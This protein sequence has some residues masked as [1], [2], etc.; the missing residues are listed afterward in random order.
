MTNARPDLTIATKVELTP[1]RVAQLPAPGMNV[2]VQIR[3]SPDGQ[4]ISF[5]Y[6][7]DGSLTR[8]LWAWDARTGERELLVRPPDGGDTDANVSR[9][10]AMRRERQRQRGFG[11]TSYAWSTEGDTLLVPVRGA[12]YVQH[13]ASGPLRMVA[14]GEP[15]C[16]DPQLNH[17]G[18]AVAF[19]RQGELYS[20]DLTD[21]TD[22]TDLTRDGAK[23]VRLTFDATPADA[24]EQLVTNGQAEFVA[25]E[26]MGRSHGFW[27]SR[28]GQ[29][30][31]VEQV[32][33]S[34]V[35]A[36]TIV[37]QGE[38][39]VESETHR[40][41]FAGGRDAAVRLGVV[42]AGGGN[43]TWLPLEGVTGADGYL[44]RV[45]WAPDG[46][47]L[48]QVLDR[49]QQTLELRRIDPRSRASVT[50]IAETSADW[51]N[52]HDDLHFVSTGDGSDGFQVLWSSE[53]T[54]TRQ[55]YLCE[56][57]GKLTRQI[58]DGPWP[59]DRVVAVDDRSRTVFFAGAES[60]LEM[61]LYRAGLDDGAPVR[62]T[63]EPGIHSAVVSPDH[64]RFVDSLSAMT[65]APAVSLRSTSA[66]DLGSEARSLFEVQ[67]PEVQALDLHP[68]E[69]VILRARDGETL[70]G[71][72]YRP[73]A[74]EPGR[75]YPVLVS[76]YG[77]PH[78]QT[79]NN[80]WAM[81]A[82]LR[83]QYL[84]RQ[85]F[86]VMKLDN[87][88]SSRRGHAFEAGLYR[89][90]GG[91]EVSDQVDGV[92]F[93]ASLPEADTARTGVYGWSYGGYLTLMCLLKAPDIF[94]AG[95]AGAPV[96]NWDG[97]DTFYTERY[98]QTPQSNPD[99]YRESAATTHAARLEGRLLLLHGMLDENVHFRHTA[100]L[101][102]ALNE[103]NR[104][105]DL[106]VF[107]G[108]R[109]GPRSEAQ[110]AALERRLAGFF[111]QHLGD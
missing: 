3:F 18:S 30:I 40:Y 101:I 22:P 32:D 79:V 58:T 43:V 4:R 63:A 107:P 91:I 33:N 77:G 96:T 93:L 1:A 45:D 67:D 10:E 92:H 88:G 99:G 12:L 8:E 104:P 59:V 49:G 7:E 66:T 29:W 60:P 69:M 110:R 109:H 74:L 72:I 24:S 35:T 106:A 85:G 15:P 108:E 111:H 2:P 103:A 37:H 11:V 82:D 89:H 38:D 73:A 86:I 83:A 39:T 55:L 71:A 28:D 98:M 62:L 20:L 53:Q 9:E 50:L 84:A 44:A 17:D 26:E 19:V 46:T 42:P 34:P 68:P 61:H 21:L 41:P 56:A 25:Q 14:S 23:P 105:Y 97:Y 54:G 5:L 47:L 76:V 51:I 36:Y 16:I 81:T 65:A 70:Y 75:K 13:G 87:R 94:K 78:V 6:S 100:R 80:S 27:W 64:E 102:N 57:S 90:M 52:L 48:V 31:A 95:V